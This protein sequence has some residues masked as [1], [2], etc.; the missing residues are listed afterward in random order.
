MTNDEID[1]LTGA[2]AYAIAALDAQAADKDA[3]LALCNKANQC[4]DDLLT[5]R[6]A[7]LKIVRAVADGRVLFGRVMDG[8]AIVPAHAAEW[9]ERAQAWSAAETPDDVVGDG[10]TQP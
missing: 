5:E 2:F 4:W 3:A 8:Q 1:Q 9:I 7:L 6:E 10:V